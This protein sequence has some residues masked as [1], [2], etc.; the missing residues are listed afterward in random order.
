ME[1]HGLVAR[2]HALTGAL[3][4]PLE[5]RY[6]VPR[7]DAVTIRMGSLK[8]IHSITPSF[9]ERFLPAGCKL[10]I[11]PF[12]SSTD[13]KSAVVTRLVDFGTLGIAA[14]RWP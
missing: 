1:G 12:E 7:L 11:M 10:E 8:L 14:R 13:C 2:R 4:A 3:A 6:G 5:L 9:Y